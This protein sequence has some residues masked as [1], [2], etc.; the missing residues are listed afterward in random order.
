MLSTLLNN[1]LVTLINVCVNTFAKNLTTP[2]QNELQKI[3]NCI[4]FNF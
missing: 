3:N 2:Q 1:V 4:I